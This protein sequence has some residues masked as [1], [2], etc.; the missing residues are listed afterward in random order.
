MGPLLGF[1]FSWGRLGTSCVNAAEAWKGTVNLFASGLSRNFKEFQRC[2]LKERC[3]RFG[4][5]V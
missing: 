4:F 2:R 3:N 5:K 1:H